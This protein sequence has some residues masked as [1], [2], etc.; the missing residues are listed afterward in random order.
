M[1][2]IT[3]VCSH[4]KTNTPVIWCQR[5]GV[6]HTIKFFQTPLCLFCSQNTEVFWFNPCPRQM[7]GNQW[8]K[9]AA[10]R[11]VI[12]HL[13]NSFFPGRSWELILFQNREGSYA[14][15]FMLIHTI[16]QVFSHPLFIL[17]YS[18]ISR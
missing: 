7:R 2:P 9:K 18:Q 16:V 3:T 5:F 17:S 12:L 13:P 8:L 1:T 10:K 11:D 6:P 14:K 15:S 4:S